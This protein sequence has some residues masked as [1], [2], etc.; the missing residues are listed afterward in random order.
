MSAASLSCTTNATMQHSQLSDPT[1]FLP[2]FCGDSW[3]FRGGEVI[4]KYCIAGHPMITYSWDI[5]G[6]WEILSKFHKDWIA[7]ISV[8]WNYQNSYFS[9]SSHSMRKLYSVESGS[10]NSTFHLEGVV[11]GL[12]SKEVAEV[13]VNKLCNEDHGAQYKYRWTQIFKY[14]RLKLGIWCQTSK[15]NLKSSL[16]V[17]KSSFKWLFQILHWLLS[18]WDRDWC[19]LILLLHSQDFEQYAKRVIYVH[20]LVN[21]NWTTV[22]KILT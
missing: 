21:W 18:L 6:W 8:E 10:S 1:I 9:V 7:I 11:S 13:I 3:A 12:I 22:K 14:N 19:Q 16:F 17:W 20:F 2:L 15:V 5:D 4:W